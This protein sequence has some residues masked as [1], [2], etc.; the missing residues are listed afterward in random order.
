VLCDPCNVP[1][2]VVW[3]ASRRPPVR[4]R[5]KKNSFFLTPGNIFLFDNDRKDTASSISM[6][7][8]GS[9][10]DIYFPALIGEMRPGDVMM[11]IDRVPEDGT[12]R[13]EV[14]RVMSRGLIGRIVM[15]ESTRRS[16]RLVSRID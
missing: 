12:S 13:N 2:G 14:W 4:S 3:W 8:P 9:K 11:F 7:T 6:Y 16:L 10:S 1:G 5:D 15:T